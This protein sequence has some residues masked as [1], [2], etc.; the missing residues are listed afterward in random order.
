MELRGRNRPVLLAPADVLGLGAAAQPGSCQDGGHG[1]GEGDGAGAAPHV[2][3]V[4]RPAARPGVA[5][6]GDSQPALAL[7]VVPPDD[8]Q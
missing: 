4:H 3:V 5:V 1:P 2:D 7:Q 6:P 8:C